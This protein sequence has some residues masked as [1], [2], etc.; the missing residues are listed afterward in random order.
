MAN[1]GTI[2]YTVIDTSD[3]SELMVYN[4]LKCYADDETHS[5]DIQ[6]EAYGCDW[7]REH[8]NCERVKIVGSR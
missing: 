7:L 8:R 4:T 6:C 2:G 5:H 3:G 1:Y